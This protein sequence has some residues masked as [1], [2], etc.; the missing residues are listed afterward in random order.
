MGLE[1][2]SSYGY[3]GSAGGF[4]G[5]KPIKEPREKFQYDYWHIEMQ[6][7]TGRYS[8]QIKA[9]NEANAIRQIEKLYEVSHSEKN[10]QL[11]PLLRQPL[12][13]E[14]YWDTFKKGW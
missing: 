3:Y 7:P 11:P 1:S 13:Q 6:Y 4:T 9:K 14:I 5:E 2:R 10:L 8:L 12:I